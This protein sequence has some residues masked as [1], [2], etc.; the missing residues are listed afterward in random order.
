MGGITIVVPDEITRQANERGVGVSVYV[1]GLLAQAA[2]RPLLPV[3]K[4]LSDQEFEAALDRLA[5]F[6]HEI[7]ALPIEAFSRESLY[8]DHD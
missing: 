3:P 7:P 1:T 8:E 5:R 4:P 6:S 2:D